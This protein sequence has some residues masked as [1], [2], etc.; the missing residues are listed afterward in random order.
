MDLRRLLGACTLAAVVVLTGGM[1]ASGSGAT[2][3]TLQVSGTGSASPVVVDVS[4]PSREQQGYVQK[5]VMAIVASRHDLAEGSLPADLGTKF[6]LVVTLR[7]RS[8]TG[9]SVDDDVQMDLYPFA[10]GG[11]YTF[12]PPDQMRQAVGK[13][14]SVKIAPGWSHF[15]DGLLA[16]MQQAGLPK[17]A[18]GETP[19][20][21]AVDPR[22]AQW[23]SWSILG[24]SVLI[25]LL[26]F[27]IGTKRA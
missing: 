24:G 19:P 18:P 7:S 5:A 20:P 16:M 27:F 14:G 23:I 1:S 10:A 8:S 3:S 6:S 25:A 11:P 22:P 15:P 12:T 26:M 21:L 17:V 13:A 4:H 9:A 2:I